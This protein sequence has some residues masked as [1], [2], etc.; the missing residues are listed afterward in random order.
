[1]GQEVIE[2]RGRLSEQRL[3][4]RSRVVG[5]VDRAQDAGVKAPELRRSRQF[6]RTG[7]GGV[8][9]VAVRIASVAVVHRA[10]AIE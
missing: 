5:D 7:H 6:E 9:G 8:T 1:V 10:V 3:V 4:D 2:P